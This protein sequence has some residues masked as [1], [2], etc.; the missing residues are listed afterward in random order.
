MNETSAMSMCGGAFGA[1]TP[2]RVQSIQNCVRVMQLLSVPTGRIS[3]CKPLQPILRFTAWL[4]A[5][6]VDT[7]IRLDD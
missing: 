2:L 3:R 5:Y 1:E 7:T 6:P 4:E